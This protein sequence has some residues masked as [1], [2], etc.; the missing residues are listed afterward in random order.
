LLPDT[1]SRRTRSIFA[2]LAADAE[3]NATDL[4]LAG[5]DLGIG[6]EIDAGVV[7]SLRKIAAVSASALFSTSHLAPSSTVRVRSGDSA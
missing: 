6:I 5:D 4:L 7:F 3:L 2:Q 1:N